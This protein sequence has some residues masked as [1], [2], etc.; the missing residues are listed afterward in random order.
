MVLLIG[1]HRVELLSLLLRQPTGPCTESL[2]AFNLACRREGSLV[3][4]NV[5]FSMQAGSAMLIR[6]PNGSGKTS[7]LRIIG[8]LGSS[9]SGGFMIN[10]QP[11]P[12]GRHSDFM[13]GRVHYMAAREDGLEP[14]LTVKENLDYW[15]SLYRG[16]A[17]QMNAAI[18]RLDV[19]HL[20]YASLFFLPI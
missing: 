4:N 2:Q 17:L 19:R 15:M 1:I 9:I 20:L 5:S 8:G 10:G 18:D 12:A 14:I 6:G 11:V 7:L 13:S 16:S 3:F